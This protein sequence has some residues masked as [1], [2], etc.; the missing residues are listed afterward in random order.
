MPPFGPELRFSIGGRLERGRRVRDRLPVCHVKHGH[1]VR[2]SVQRSGDP[3]SAREKYWVAHQR[4]TVRRGTATTNRS[5]PEVNDIAD[6]E[7]LRRELRR[8]LG[9]DLHLEEEKQDL[10]RRLAVKQRELEQTRAKVP[11]S[12]S[13]S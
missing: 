2:A 13:T 9:E 11:R 3:G 12:V 5:K 4:I 6:V 10:E 7:A 8:L 1:E